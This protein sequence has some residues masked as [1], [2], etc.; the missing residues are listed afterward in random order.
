MSTRPILLQDARGLIYGSG[1]TMMQLSLLGSLYIV[2]RVLN[3][4]RK[5]QRRPI[6]L[7]F[8]FYVAITDILLYISVMTDQLHDVI[9][10]YSWDG[11]MCTITACMVAVASSGNMALVCSVSF[12]A[13]S[14]IVLNKPI[15]LGKHDW[16]LLLTIFT[17]VFAIT[18]IVYTGTGQS[19][20]WCYEQM[21]SNNKSVVIASFCCESIL[22]LLTFYFSAHVLYTLNSV[23]LM[24]KDLLKTNVPITTIAPSNIIKTEMNT[25]TSVTPNTARTHGSETLKKGKENVMDRAARKLLI[26]ILNYFV[27]W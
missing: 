15:D 22:F 7:R 13:Y 18:G 3:R 21:Y 25:A 23:K 20:Y 10:G 9:F 2:Y 6:T 11:A 19:W 27:Q 8:P 12:Q 16:K 4:W 5:Q 1:M 24:R 26:F 17:F 14:S